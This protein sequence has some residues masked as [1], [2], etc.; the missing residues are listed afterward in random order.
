M[1]N[2]GDWR[3]FDTREIAGRLFAVE[4]CTN[5]ESYRAKDIEDAPAVVNREEKSDDKEEQS[6]SDDGSGSG[7]DN[8][9]LDDDD[10][11]TPE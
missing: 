4:Q 5:C 3:G 9:E 2:L 8:T 11:W 1:C 6:E 10:R 7:S